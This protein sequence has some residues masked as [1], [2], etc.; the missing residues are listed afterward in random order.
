M[1]H[2]D[3][4]TPVSS[5]FLYKNTPSYLGVF[6]KKIVITAKLV[7][8]PYQTF[9]HKTRDGIGAYNNHNTNYGRYNSFFSL[10][11]AFLI[12]HGGHP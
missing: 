6:L 1:E 8:R 2:T 11:N 5:F 7:H 4:D 12:A 3:G 10:G 9:H